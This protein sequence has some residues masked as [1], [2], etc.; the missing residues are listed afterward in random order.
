MTSIGLNF[1]DTFD[2]YFAHTKIDQTGSDAKYP[3]HLYTNPTIPLD[4]PVFALALHFS[5]NYN[6]PLD[7]STPLFHGLDQYARFEELLTKC[8]R[9]HE[10]ELHAFGYQ[11][12]DLGMHSI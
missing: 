9:E 2:I 10:M 3:C 12:E 6:I 7:M 5:Y 11:F 1:F 4:C 8:L